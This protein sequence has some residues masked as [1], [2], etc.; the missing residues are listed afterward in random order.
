M[1][2]P[3]KVALAATLGATLL[4]SG[5][6]YALWTSS[7]NPGTAA[8][9]ITGDS[10]I[11]ALDSGSWTDLVQ[12]QPI[13]NINNFRVAPKDELGYRQ[14]FNV[15]FAGDPTTKNLM[16][17][18]FLDGS[19]VNPA[20]LK[21]RGIT[22]QSTVKNLD[23]GESASSDLSTSSLTTG[24]TFTGSLPTGGARVEVSLNFKMDS[25]VTAEDTKKLQTLVS[26]STLSV[27]QITT[28]VAEKPAPIELATNSNNSYQLQ[29]EGN[30]DPTWSIVSGELPTGLSLSEDGLISG[31]PKLSMRR[32]AV[33]R[34]TN[35]AGSTD[36]P[37][38]ITVGEPIVFRTTSLPD[39]SVNV[40]YSEQLDV[41]GNPTFAVTSG[42][43]PN[44]LTLSSNG[45]L[46]GLPTTN[47]YA[48]AAFTITATGAKG[49]SSK[50][51]VINL[52][53][54]R[55]GMADPIGYE[56]V[57]QVIPLNIT[58]LGKDS[59]LTVAYT[60]NT[61]P[62]PY[63]QI[64]GTNLVLSPSLRS[65]AYSFG[66]TASN[67][68][69][70]SLTKGYTV[71]VRSASSVQ[72]SN[73]STITASSVANSP[74]YYNFQFYYNPSTTI[75]VKSGTLPAGVSISPTGKIYGYMKTSGTYTAVLQSGVQTM[76]VKFTG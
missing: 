38:D 73:N 41:S 52:V 29:A 46:S 68:T 8:S 36:V 54:P 47:A 53:P 60:N 20:A 27:E 11:T 42:S 74:R 72:W 49:A 1:K 40:P 13:S 35:P 14:L 33:A 22:V 34:A 10:S 71:N 5:S 2:K 4:I 75:T 50:S 70:A 64:S 48:Q 56:G 25:S 37:L 43:L 55:F 62:S 32:L 58:G 21:A 51:F 30:P 12:N 63:I 23:T 9:I 45:L 44:G 26:S 6:T 31:T 19:S 76:T 57:E 28:P 61:S 66:L 15:K 18:K 17:L 39:F 3:V 24:Y 65:G 59:D 16:Q 69:G 7:V 67:K